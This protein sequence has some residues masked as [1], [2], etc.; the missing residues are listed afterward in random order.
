MFV[1]TAPLFKVNLLL[2]DIPSGSCSI[3][4]YFKGVGS[5]SKGYRHH[6]V[7]SCR[8]AASDAHMSDLSDRWC[9]SVFSIIERQPEHIP[10]GS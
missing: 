8:N 2:A 9:P 5:E 3:F 4:S 7:M 10:C 6:L 1:G